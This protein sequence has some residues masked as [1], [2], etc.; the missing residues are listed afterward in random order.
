MRTELA[1]LLADLQDHEKLLEPHFVALSTFVF[2]AG[3]GADEEVLRTVIGWLRWQHDQRHAAASSDIEL[4]QCGRLLGLIDVARW[5]LQ[6]APV[7]S[8]VPAVEP[9]SHSEDFLR[10]LCMSGDTSNSKVIADLGWDKSEVSRVGWKLIEKGLATKR[11][12]GRRNSWEIT[13]RGQR[14]LRLLGYD[15]ADLE[16]R[17]IGMLEPLDAQQ[18]EVSGNQERGE[19]RRLEAELPKTRRATPAEESGLADMTLVL[20]GAG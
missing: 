11:K 15:D 18:R 17:T 14:T 1:T 20:A 5:A 9:G 16:S 7:A 13:P 12:I 6:R 3:L 2:D 10:L 8:S 19:L 4:E